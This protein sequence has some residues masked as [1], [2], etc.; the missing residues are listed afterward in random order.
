MPR[1]PLP[2]WVEQRPPKFTST[3]NLRRWLY[4]E[5]GSLQMSLA[6]VILD[7]VGPKLNDWC[8]HKAT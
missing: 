8:R 1:V 6:E 2:Y 3:Q 4:V 5:I 7:W